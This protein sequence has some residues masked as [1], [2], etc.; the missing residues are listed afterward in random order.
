MTFPVNTRIH[1]TIALA[2]SL[3]L[4]AA[5]LFAAA[6]WTMLQPLARTATPSRI[7][8]ET[9]I[10]TPSAPEPTSTDEFGD[11][12]GKG[13]GINEIK[14]PRPQRARKAD[15]EQAFLSRDPV[16]TG[17]IGDIGDA[18]TSSITTISNPPPLMP[19]ASAEPA[20]IA[21]SLAPPAPITPPH[22]PKREIAIGPAPSTQ[23]TTPIS[24]ISLAPSAPPA[25]P[26]TPP[27]ASASTGK[28]ADPAP[29]SESESDPFT[30]A[31]SVTFEAGQVDVKLGRH[32]KTTRPKLTLAGRYDL[33]ALGGASVQIKA[34]IDAT[35]KVVDVK[36]IHPSGSDNV[37]QPARVAVYDWW[38]E[39]AKSADGKPKGDVIIFSINWR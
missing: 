6:R 21:P 27:L 39:P 19:S 4:H 5:L 37:D 32:V 24:R 1:W 2:A 35:G 12:R 38:F 13:K 14:A 31:G 18:F 23:P 22:P 29:M 8:E 25:P 28:P 34:K 15:E 9:A 33:V 20:P 16:G 36:I 3:A 10:Y 11:A 17:E 26:V 30:L 7:V